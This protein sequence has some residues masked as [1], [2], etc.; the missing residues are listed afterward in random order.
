MRAGL[1]RLRRL[2]CSSTMPSPRTGLRFANLSLRILLNGRN[3][4]EDV[5]LRPGD[6]IF[7]PEKF[8]AN[9]KKYVPYSFNI[10][11]PYPTAFLKKHEKVNKS[12]ETRLISE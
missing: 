1:L 11:P 4:A 6:M 10:T 7:V 5:H 9:F 2:K 8:I 12:R 3:V